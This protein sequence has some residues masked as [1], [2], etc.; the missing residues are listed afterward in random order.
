MTTLEFT[1]SSS[2]SLLSKYLDCRN[3]QECD[4]Y[5]Q[6]ILGRCVPLECP[7]PLNTESQI[8]DPPKEPIT[9]GSIVEVKCKPG[10]IFGPGTKTT[11]LICRDNENGR[12]ELVT[13][14]GSQKTS[15]F[16]GKGL[17]INYETQSRGGLE[18]ESEF[19][20]T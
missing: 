15:C 14:D 4:Q 17:F 20:Y 13:L 16:P 1:Y 12:G 7:K 19:E 8:F 6:C 9:I 18:V 11:H 5:H 10:K 2:T 3:D